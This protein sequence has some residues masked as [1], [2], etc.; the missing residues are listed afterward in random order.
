MHSSLPTQRS[1]LE[2]LRQVGRPVM[3]VATSLMVAGMIVACGGGDGLRAGAL[4]KQFGKASDG[5]PDGME[6]INGTPAYMA[7]EYVL[8][9]EAGERSDVF[10]GGVIL[11]EMLSGQRAF[12]GNDIK[13]IMQ[14]VA[15]EDL[16]LPE[17]ATVDG[18]F[19]A[20]TGISNRKK[21]MTY[22]KNQLVVK[23]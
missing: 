9:R 20:K 11:F 6:R 16:L 14:R 23:K 22:L 12:V 10:A 3:A 19:S 2:R 18:I 17:N 4:D 13:A 8:R 7:P 1:G 21:L 15:D 5:T